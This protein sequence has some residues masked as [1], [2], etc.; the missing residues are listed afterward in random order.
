[1]KQPLSI[2]ERDNDEEGVEVFLSKRKHCATHTLNLVATTDAGKTQDKCTIYKKYYCLVFAKAQ[3][4]WNKQSRS[5]KASDV[6]KNNI[7]FQLQVL[8]VT[9]WI[10]VND[11]AGRLIAIFDNQ[12]DLKAFKQ[13][14]QF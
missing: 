9:Q 6:I 4:I 1:M 12:D 14:F 3:E 7:G 8:T 2:F 10:S 11:A 13:T 5:S